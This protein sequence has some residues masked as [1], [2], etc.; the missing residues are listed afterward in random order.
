MRQ[1]K[2]KINVIVGHVHFQTTKKILSSI[3]GSIFQDILSGSTTN[4]SI[5]FLHD[6]LY[7]NRNPTHFHHIL[8]FLKAGGFPVTLPNSA[9]GKNALAIEAAYYGLSDLVQILQP[10]HEIDYEGLLPFQIKLIRDKET[11]ARFLFPQFPIPSSAPPFQDL[12]CLISSPTSYPSNEEF[13]TLH[14]LQQII[15]LPLCHNTLPP[16]STY[17]N[18]ILF[19]TETILQQIPGRPVTVPSIEDFRSNFNSQHHDLLNSLDPILKTGNMII[20][21]GAIV[22]ALSIQQDIPSTTNDP[23]SPIWN[24]DIDIFFYGITA[25]K[26][27]QLTHD[28]FLALPGETWFIVRG[29]HVVNIMRDYKPT[30]RNHL[31]KRETIQIILRL[32]KSPLEILYGFDVDCCSCAYDGH[33]LWMSERCKVAFE[34][35]RNILNPLHSWPKQPSYE[36]RLAKYGARGF[37]VWV[38]GLQREIVRWNCINKFLF[39]DLTGLARLL[40][41]DLAFHHEPHHLPPPKM[42]P[43]QTNNY[44]TPMTSTPSETILQHLQNTITKN[45]NYYGQHTTHT[46]VPSVY[47][48][49]ETSWDGSTL[50]SSTEPTLTRHLAWQQ[51]LHHN[52][53]QPCTLPA[54]MTDAWTTHDHFR[55]NRHKDILKYDL[56]IIYYQPAY[57][58]NYSS[59]PTVLP[60]SL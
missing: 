4:A 5:Q 40:K 48:I 2:Q 33:N 31:Q 37:H 39:A 10:I 12:L 55:T 28:I 16:A 46:I 22:R 41:L 9:S 44:P 30:N 42:S 56:D 15:P 18:E 26:A 19:R 14:H 23:S 25:P 11:Q 34:T 7:I 53:T 21:G 51:I 60:H 36:I 43:P 54:H 17:Q 24:G 29:K 20:A 6:T 50:P 27:T 52:V 3:S 49:L 13:N 57:L 32:Y 8:N 35:K 45:T 1:E 38:P 59:S 47:S 58:S